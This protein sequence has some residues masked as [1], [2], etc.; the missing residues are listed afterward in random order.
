M[1]GGFGVD[2]GGGFGVD[3]GGGFGVDTDGGFG[4]TAGRVTASLDVLLSMMDPRFCGVSRDFCGG[5][6]AAGIVDV[7]SGVRVTG[8]GSGS[9]SARSSGSGGS[10]TGAAGAVL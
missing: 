8:A 2:T 3:T 10:K 5:A 1:G 7:G 9:G 4:V 6:M